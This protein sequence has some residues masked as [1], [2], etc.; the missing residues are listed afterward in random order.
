MSIL[1]DEKNPYKVPSHVNI[2]DPYFEL[3]LHNAFEAGCKAQ[4]K[5]DYEYMMQPCTEHRLPYKPAFRVNMYKLKGKWYYSHRYQCESCMSN[6]EKE[7]K[8]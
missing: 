8:G 2:D 4:L 1:S 7:V 6:F 3:E 5:A